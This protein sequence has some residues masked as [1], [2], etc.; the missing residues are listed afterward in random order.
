LHEKVVV[1]EM[2]LAAGTTKAVTQLLMLMPR[3]RMGERRGVIRAMYVIVQ[4][5]MGQLVRTASILTE[6]AT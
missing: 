1:V 3:R 5:G 2:T 6:G 4:A